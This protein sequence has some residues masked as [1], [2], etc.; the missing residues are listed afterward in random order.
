MAYKKGMAVDSTIG[1][2]KLNAAGSPIGVVRM[3]PAQAYIGIPEL[4]KSF[5]NELNKEAWSKIKEKIDYIYVN[6]DYALG[7]LNEEAGFAEDVKSQVRAGKRLLFKPNLVDPENIVPVTHVEGTG[8]TACT[9]WPFVAA[10]MR[11]F[12]D[13]L[14][15]IYPQPGAT[16]G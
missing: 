12:H 7:R 13:K 14:G 1:K 10:L 3:D 5:I 6:L 9:Q 2:L 4:L 8:G 15:I 16:R 11:W